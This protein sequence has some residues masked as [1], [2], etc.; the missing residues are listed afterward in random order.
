MT[1]AEYVKLS[2][3]ESNF[4]QANLLGAQLEL[5]KLI[6]SFH[7]FRVLRDEELIEGTSKEVVKLERLLPKADY[8]EDRGEDDSENAAEK[9]KRLSLEEEIEK[10]RAKLSMLRDEI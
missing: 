6:Q 10:V 7:K 5:L 3:S 9:H 2:P 8:K 1:N 4:G